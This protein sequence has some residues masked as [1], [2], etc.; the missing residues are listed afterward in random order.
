MGVISKYT[1]TPPSG[2]VTF[3]ISKNHIQSLAKFFYHP[4]FELEYYFLKLHE[5]AFGYAF[6]L[7]LNYQ[8]F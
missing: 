1:I 4:N 8:P 7:S 2:G 3:Y 6:T 5:H